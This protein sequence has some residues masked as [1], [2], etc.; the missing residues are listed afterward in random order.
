MFLHTRLYFRR[1]GPRCCDCIWC[2]T[3]N[4]YCR[5]DFEHV[6]DNNVWI[7]DNLMNLYIWVLKPWFIIKVESTC[8]ITRYIGRFALECLF[9]LSRTSNFFSYL[10]AVTITVDRSANSDLCQ[11]L[12]LLAK[13]VLLRATP[14]ATWNLRFL[15]HIRN[16]RD[17]HFWMPCS[18]RWS[19]HYLFQCLRWNDNNN[20]QYSMSE[21]DLIYSI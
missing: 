17:P 21:F 4:T 12:R 11:H 18:W 6:Q 8:I 5:H 7:C 16:T 15:G 9:V 14:T 20:E 2:K 3:T 19:K 13:R 10:A 1:K